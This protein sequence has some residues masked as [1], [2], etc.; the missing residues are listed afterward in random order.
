PLDFP[1]NKS[2]VQ[3]NE[4]PP[5]TN[6]LSVTLRLNIPNH[7]SETVIFHK[8]AGENRSPRLFLHPNNSAPLPVCSTNTNMNLFFTV[9]TGLKTNKWYHIGY[10]LSEPKK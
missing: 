1:A 10:T 7:D 5:V 6:E 8:G 4:L 9:G 3:N 2:I